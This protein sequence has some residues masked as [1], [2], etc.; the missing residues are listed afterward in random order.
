M[1]DFPSSQVFWSAPPDAVISTMGRNSVAGRVGQCQGLTSASGVW[2]A[3]T[4]TLYIP[5]QVEQTCIA[6]QMATYNGTVA[7][8]NT[9]VGIMDENGARLVSIGPTAQAGT[10]VVQVFDIA[11]TTLTPGTYLIACGQTLGTSTFFRTQPSAIILRACGVRQEA[12][13][14]IPATATFANVT[15]AYVP[16]VVVALKSLAL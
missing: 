13:S 3:A 5:V 7:A 14:T 12:V 16:H 9:D 8:G 2:P 4:R 15:A 6:Y 1:G 11:D 10:S